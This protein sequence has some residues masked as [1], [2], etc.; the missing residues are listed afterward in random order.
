[1]G[2]PCSFPLFTPPLL[3][4]TLFLLLL[5]SQD[6]PRGLIIRPPAPASLLDPSA[7][8]FY[9][10]TTGI[11][12][13]FSAFNNSLLYGRPLASSSSISLLRRLEGCDISPCMNGGFCNK[14]QGFSGPSTFCQWSASFLSLF[15]SFFLSVSAIRFFSFIVL[16]LLLLSQCCWLDW[17]YLRASF[18]LL[19]Q[20]LCDG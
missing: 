16:L 2:L 7:S 9:P 17:P 1:M 20:S 12:V 3:S 18:L 14:T 8:S 19:V 13:V 4:H 5:L 10:N 11:N 6:F 15:L